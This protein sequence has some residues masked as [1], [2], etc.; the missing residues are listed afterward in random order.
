MK[1]ASEEGTRND[2]RY[3]GDRSGHEGNNL[4]SSRLST[5]MRLVTGTLS[6]RVLYSRRELLQN[7]ARSHAGTA[8]I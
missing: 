8:G 7:F 3:A 1:P 4:A 5:A 6:N 2:G